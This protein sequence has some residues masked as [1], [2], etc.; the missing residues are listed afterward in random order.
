MI[1]IWHEPRSRRHQGVH[2]GHLHDSTAADSRSITWTPNSLALLAS[3]A[4]ERGHDEEVFSPV[5]QIAG[6][7]EA[8][9]T[10]TMLRVL[11]F[12]SLRVTV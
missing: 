5:S 10:M 9:V 8:H 4:F 11:G 2:E 1:Q 12:Q 7:Q 3:R 6:Y